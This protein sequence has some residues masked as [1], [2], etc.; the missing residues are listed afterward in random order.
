MSEL[1]CLY[2]EHLPNYYPVRVSHFSLIPDENFWEHLSL[3]LPSELIFCLFRTLCSERF[4]RDYSAESR[5]DRLEIVVKWFQVSPTDK[6]LLVQLKSDLFI[7]LPRNLA[8][9]DRA[10]CM[11][12]S[13]VNFIDTKLSINFE[14][15]ELHNIFIWLFNAHQSLLPFPQCSYVITI[16][17]G[18]T[19][20]QSN[21]LVTVD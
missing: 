9:S 20:W 21:L 17:T 7:F 19:S 14:I 4:I 10:T 11:I 5:L 15:S 1:F 13:G 2:I 6:P 8:P 18:W 16:K 3:A 12:A